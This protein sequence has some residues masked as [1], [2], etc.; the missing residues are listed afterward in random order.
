LFD[1]LLKQSSSIWAR[2]DETVNNLKA[3]G[4]KN[5]S[6][7]MDTA[8]NA[9]NWNDLSKKSHEKYIVVN[10]NKNGEHFA[11]ELIDDI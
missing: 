10:L 3:Y 9:Y 11:A 8:L 1:F 7:F 2:D 4:F 6:F 5:V